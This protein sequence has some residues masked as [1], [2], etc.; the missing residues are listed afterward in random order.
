M[1]QTLQADLNHIFS[2]RYKDDEYE[3]LP[4]TF[5]IIVRDVS[6]LLLSACHTSFLPS[7]V[8][9]LKP[10]SPFKHLCAVPCCLTCDAATTYDATTTVWG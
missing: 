4:P 8:S 10:P 9:Q 1:K 2:R 5:T 6:T 7:G 3:L